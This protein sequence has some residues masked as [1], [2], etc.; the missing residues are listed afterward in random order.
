MYF[1]DVYILPSIIYKCWV[2]IDFYKNPILVI[3]KIRII[4]VP[5]RRAPEFSSL[6]LRGDT[7]H[8]A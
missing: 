8:K 1:C 7:K 6:E 3:K 4:P 2:V 5:S